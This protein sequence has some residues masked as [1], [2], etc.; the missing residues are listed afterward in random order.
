MNQQIR[1]YYE[2]SHFRIDIRERVLLRDG[3]PVPLTPKL[4]DTLLVLIEHR[5]TIVTRDELLKHL[6]PDSFVEE[7]NLTQNVSMLRKLLGENPELHQYIETIPR[8]GYK[9]IAEVKEVTEVNEVTEPPLPTPANL[10]PSDPGLHSLSMLSGQQPGVA[11]STGRSGRGK[12]ILA[13]LGLAVLAVSLL[14]YAAYKGVNSREPGATTPQV[15]RLTYNGK[16]T[17]VAISPD[18]RY[19]VQAIIDGGQQ[20]LWLRQVATASEI[21]IVPPANVSYISVTF[22]TDGQFVY[23]VRGYQ[24]GPSDGSFSDRGTLYRMSMLGK[25]EKRLI[26]NVDGHITLSPDGQSLAYIRQTFNQGKSALMIAKLDGTDEREL[27]VRKFPDN[28][29]PGAVAWSPDGRIIACATNNFTAADPYRGIVAIS[30]A[31]GMERPLGVKHWY[32]SPRRLAWLGDGSGL[33][34]LSPEYSRAPNQI[35]RL[36]YPGNGARRLISDLSD[37]TDL[38]LAVTAG[39]LAVVR[40]DRVVNLWVAPSEDVARARAI[41]SGTGREDGIRGLTWTPDNR[42]VYRSMAG[43]MPQIWISNADGSSPKQLTSDGNEHFDPALTPDGQS[44]IWSS[45]AAG[46]RNIWRMNLDGSNPRQVTAGVN[47]WYPEYTQDGKWLVYVTM[48]HS[49]AR[50][51]ATGGE[52]VR[53][54]NGLSWRPTLSPDSQWI[55]FNRLDEASGQWMIAVMPIDGGGVLK[56]FDIPS[57]SIFR[58][59][60]WTP[61]GKSIAYPVSTDNATNIWCQPLDGSPPRRLT[62]F[63]QQIIFDF[64]WSRDGARLALSRGIVN[65]DVVI[66]GNIR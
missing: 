25:W 36:D 17:R 37:Y 60:R 22:S 40:A 3:R 13:L 34:V 35:W 21:E 63:S 10:P 51:P 46:H 61:D 57:P 2:F 56:I 48:T 16:A 28:F 41:T 18:G 44:I 49:L 31:D 11:V 4:F 30:A 5:Q 29:L 43:E 39:S 12:M 15:N 55:A 59:I 65:S 53:L 1:R 32:G 27:A 14:G 64:A 47:E 8:R 66:I 24:N 7:G 19:V 42:L 26:S 62:D 45:S 50:M 23:F 6:W 58:A 9:F 38:S 52:S 54:T 33:L 20:S